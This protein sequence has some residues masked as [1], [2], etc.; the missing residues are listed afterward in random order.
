MAEVKLHVERDC[1]L[2][3]KDVHWD[4]EFHIGLLLVCEELEIES[5]GI[6]N[7]GLRD[8]DLVWLWKLVVFNSC[9][10]CGQASNLDFAAEGVAC[11]IGVDALNLN[12][13]LRLVEGHIELL[14]D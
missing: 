8:W 11:S 12:L 10:C 1:S 3:C 4:G 7:F 5:E 13:F 14:F 6:G 9:C 2:V